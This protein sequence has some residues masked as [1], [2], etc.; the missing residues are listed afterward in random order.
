MTVA[1]IPPAMREREAMGSAED[2]AAREIAERLQRE[3]PSWIVIFGAYTRQFICLPRFSVLPG[4][5]VVALYPEAAA[6]RMSEVERLH[7]IRE[8][9]SQWEP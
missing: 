8:G 4:L 1:T 3:H 6:D 7:K 5:M 2:D 9:L